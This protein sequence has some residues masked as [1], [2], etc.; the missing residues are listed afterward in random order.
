[1]QPD[2]LLTLL[3]ARRSYGLKD[4]LPDPVE[5][6]L[7]EQ[8]LEAANW[9]PSHGQ[10]EPWRF[11]VFTG[12]GRH[13]L[14]AVFGEAY[15]Q[16]TPAEKF[17]AKA[18]QSQAERAFAAPVW[19]SLGMTPGTSPKMPE[20]EELSAVA[21][22]AHNLHLMAH[23]LGLACKWT[24]GAVVMHSHVAS[25]LRL[26]PP[27]RLL[28]FYYVG[29]PAIVPPTGARRPLVDKVRWVVE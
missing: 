16:L 18:Q 26:E 28:G 1:M 23:S 21:I 29:K 8:L 19:I 27:S 10:T 22:A 17:D 4:I 6:A 7:I 20:W 2:T 12:S 25:F 15:R 24:S 14:A 13:K 5:P 9:A 11:T 3:K